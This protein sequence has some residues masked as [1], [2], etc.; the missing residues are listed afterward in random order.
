MA[1][2]DVFGARDQLVR[3][4]VLSNLVVVSLAAKGG[5]E[6]IF[7]GQHVVYVSLKIKNWISHR[8]LLLRFRGHNGLG[9]SSP[10]LALARRAWLT[11]ASGFGYCNSASSRA[12]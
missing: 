9:N 3:I 11:R 10:A 1:I 5:M 6:L 4:L 2:E 7:H 8:Y 12:Q